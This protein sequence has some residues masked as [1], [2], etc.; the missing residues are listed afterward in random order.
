LGYRALPGQAVL[1]SCSVGVQHL[2][3][4]RADSQAAG[5]KRSTSQG[6]QNRQ[7]HPEIEADFLWLGGTCPGVS[8]L[9]RSSRVRALLGSYS[10]GV[11]HLL[12]VGVAIQA[13]WRQEHFLRVARS[14]R[15]A[16]QWRQTSYGLAELAMV[17]LGPVALP[18]GTAP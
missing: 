7:D 1:G 5:R 6:S 18:G 14:G 16:L 2:P 11:Q 4:V 17:F 10:V 15:T 12:R 8:G 9:W 3:R 13:A